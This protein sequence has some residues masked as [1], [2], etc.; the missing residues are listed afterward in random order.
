METAVKA[1]VTR[2]KRLYVCKYSRFISGRIIEATIAF[3]KKNIQK[4]YPIPN[5]GCIKYE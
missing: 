3:F 4:P 2:N 1:S 5:L